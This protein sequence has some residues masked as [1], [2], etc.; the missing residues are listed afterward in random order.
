MTKIKFLT[1]SVCD[2]PDDLIRQ[3]DITVAPIFV[4]FGGQSFADDGIELKRDDFYRQ[5]RTL[6]DYPKT[7]AM[8]PELARTYIDRAYAD[9]DHL[10]IITTPKGLSGIYNSMRLGMAHLPP[11]RV[12]L[13]DS[14]QLSIGMGWQ[15]LIGA[16]IAQQTGDVELTKR[17]I[18]SAQANQHVYCV[19][20]SLDF[21]HRSGRVSWALASIGNFLNIKPVVQSHNGDVHPIARVRTFNRALDKLA[22]LAHQNA[23]YDKFAILHILNEEGFHALQDRLADILPP[24]TIVGTVGPALGTHVG[25]GAVG[26]AAVSKGWKD[27]IST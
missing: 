11:E 22:E 8:S 17:A 24:D 1:D 25:P 26:F 5:L 3:Y 6:E 16:Q 19:V 4:N 27:A 13:I 7:S 21:L 15:V 12:T 10:F 2:I 14:G 18:M 20:G 23:P 9:A